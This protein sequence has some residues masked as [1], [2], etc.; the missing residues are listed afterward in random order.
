[1]FAGVDVAVYVDVRVEVSPTAAAGFVGPHSAEAGGGGGADRHKTHL[2]PTI[3]AFRRCPPH[4]DCPFNF[5]LL[6]TQDSGPRF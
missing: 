1:M 3:H 6:T 4:A 5:F 2:A